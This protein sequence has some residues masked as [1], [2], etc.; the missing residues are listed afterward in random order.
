MSTSF[1][2]VRSTLSALLGSCFALAITPAGS[3][4]QNLLQNAGFETNGGFVPPPSAPPWAFG[5]SVA[6]C[7]AVHCGS[8]ANS[9]T[10][11]VVVPEA[12]G[13]GSVSQTVNV[14]K[15]GTYTLS[16]FYQTVFT[17][18]S[19]IAHGLTAAMN[20]KTVADLTLG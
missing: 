4:A 19:P 16:F 5:G 15:S 1:N 7:D 11:F 3:F 20:G 12:G 9:G 18:L 8:T 2:R 6:V 10:A 14:T 13:I 17:A